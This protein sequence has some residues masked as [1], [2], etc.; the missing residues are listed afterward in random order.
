MFVID[1][2]MIIG[3]IRKSPLTPLCQRGETDLFPLRKRGIEGDFSKNIF[4]LLC[5]P[6]A[7]VDSYS[8]SGILQKDSGQ[9]YPPLAAPQATRGD[10]GR[11]DK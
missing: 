6:M 8:A 11:N 7:H 2:K 1:P 4:T 9:V 3:F 10:Q 5:E